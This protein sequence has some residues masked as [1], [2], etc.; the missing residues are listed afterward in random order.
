MRCF[1]AGS[2]PRAKKISSPSDIFKLVSSQPGSL[3][4]IALRNL[5]LGIEL[6]SGA[7]RPL[8]VTV[9]SPAARDGKS[10]IASALASIFA[11]QGRRVLLVDAAL[12]K[13]SLSTALKF[14]NKKGLFDLLGGT[15][16]S[17]LL[18]QNGLLPGLDFLP[19]G[20]GPV[21]GHAT[22]LPDKMRTLT[23]LLKSKFDV[24]VYDAPAILSLAEAAI[25]AQCSDNTI[26]LARSRK[27][28][29]SQIEQAA[30]IL[31]SAHVHAI[32]FVI[33]DLRARDAT[34]AA[35]G[36]QGFANV[37]VVSNDVNRKN[38]QRDV[39]NA[40]QGAADSAASPESV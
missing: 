7:S 12:H 13:D 15:P 35:S 19:A 31:R 3:A 30:A 18:L 23:Q 17:D 4:V 6:N 21:S 22:I 14:E 11:V 29:T 40:V 38:Q 25:F 32:Q 8:V 33:N 10:F 27:T 2:V 1:V 16:W 9:T 37:N 34:N 5:V 26:L 39:V 36:V 24:V 20:T 28:L